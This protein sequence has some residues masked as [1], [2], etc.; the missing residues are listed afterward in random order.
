M[1]TASWKWLFGTMTVGGLGAIIF[2][3]MAP[4]YVLL[5]IGIVGLIVV[6]SIES[7]EKSA[8][9]NPSIFPTIKPFTYGGSSESLG[10]SDTAKIRKG[11]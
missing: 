9:T 1:S 10:K 8:K 11:S 7:R 3:T 4:A 2:H 5:F 6:L